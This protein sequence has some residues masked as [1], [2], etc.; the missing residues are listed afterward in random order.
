MCAATKGNFL[1]FPWYCSVPLPKCCDHDLRLLS[2]RHLS[3]CGKPASLV[4]T[5][6]PAKLMVILKVSQCFNGSPAALA[7]IGPC[8]FLLYQL[9][10]QF[11]EFWHI[12]PEKQVIAWC[13]PP[14]VIVA[15]YP[16]ITC[17]TTQMVTR[18]LWSIC[19][20]PTRNSTST[21]VHWAATFTKALSGSSDRCVT[22]RC[23]L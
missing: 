1:S 16:E 19:P 21:K 12:V 20:N 6:N 7:G 14:M 22:W 10:F 11:V 2:W 13:V 17:Y 9:C 8:S 23:R 18:S 3:E 15:Y 5:A 4:F